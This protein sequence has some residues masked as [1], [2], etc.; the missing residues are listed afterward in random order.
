MKMTLEK[1]DDLMKSFGFEQ[2]E[3]TYSELLKAYSEKHR[4]YHTVL[5][6]ES[7]LRYIDQIKAIA[8]YPNEIELALWFHD[9]IYNPHSSNN[10]LKSAKWAI[11]FLSQN[12][13]A[14]NVLTRVYNLIMVTLHDSPAQSKDEEILVDIDLS[15]L[16]TPSD[17]YELF[18]KA[19]RK[20]YK[21][22]PLFMFRKKRKKILLS[23]LKRNRIYQN[24]YFY[25]KLEV[26]ARENLSNAIS[27]L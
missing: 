15:I 19:I 27:R 16:G 5:H 10:E 8:E 4:F 20:E 6:I 9:A 2:N 21:W 12:A 17:V 1:W 23:F 26:Q 25:E 7:C 22:V 11:D 14:E 3:A 13:A 18:E 24:K